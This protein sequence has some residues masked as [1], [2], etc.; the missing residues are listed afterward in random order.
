MNGNW[1]ALGVLASAT[2]VVAWWSS[3]LKSRHDDLVGAALVLFMAWPLTTL[4][5]HLL[6]AP[7]RML[8]GPVYDALFATALWHSIRAEYRSWKLYL[9]SILVIQVFAH[10]TYQTS[11]NQAGALYRYRVEGNIT[12]AA[13]LLCIFIMGA[14]DVVV[15]FLDRGLR[16]PRDLPVEGRAP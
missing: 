14:R 6:P 12:Y 15:Y 10:V 8:L 3:R 4:C 13:Q 5:D 16:R 1:L 7:Q 9:M 2:L 11:F